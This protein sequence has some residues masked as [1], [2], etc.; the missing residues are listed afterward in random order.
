MAY[1]SPGV[2]I[3]EQSAQGP[4]VPLG[5][6]T[7]AFVGPALSGPLFTPT[8]ITNFTQ[9]RDTF[10]GYISAPPH[11]LA[12]AAYGFFQN[13]GSI[14]Y[15]VR[16]G[17]ALRAHLMLADGA[18]LDTVLI[19][20]L[21]EGPAGNTITAQVQHHQIVTANAAR[22]TATV[23]T[24]SN[25]LIVVTDPLQASTFRPGDIVTIQGQPERVKI[26][27][28]R[29]VEIFLSDLLTG[30]YSSGI[31]RIAD[32]EIGQESFRVQSGAGLEAGSSIR[33]AQGGTNEN[34]V[35]AGFIGD[36]VFLE[37]GLSNTYTMANGDAAVSIVSF[38]FGV[39][40]NRPGFPAEPFSN[41]AMD[42]RHSRYFGKIV[43]SQHVSAQLA[44]LPSASPPPV[45]RPAVI[46][47]TALAGGTSDNL[48]AINASHYQQA[49][50]EL[51][52][53]DDVNIVAAPDRTDL[54][55]QQAII[56]HCSSMADRFAILDP[57]ANATPFGPGGILDQRAGLESQ[58]GFAALYYPRIAIAGPTGGDPIRDSPSGHLAGVYAR[59]D[60][61]RGV[62]KA[63]ANTIIEGA[64]AL[65]RRL[66]DGEL[67]EL[68]IEGVNVIH[69]FPNSVRPRVWGARTTSPPAETPWRYINVRRLLLQI[70]E[71]IQESIR[72][73]VFEP[74]DLALWEKLKRI[75]TQ[76]LTQVWRDGAL[77]G[78]T[79][80]DAFYVKCD[81]E[82]NPEPIRQLGQVIVEIGVA[83]VRP[84]E[85][86]I[87]R[88]GQWEGGSSAGES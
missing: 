64:V 30:T 87:I 10:G 41:L 12:H 70:E 28:V 71:S 24:A 61:Q 81:E 65:E 36:R 44:D 33:I 48:A 79:A 62:H 84:A 9:F 22:L 88:I 73:S 45:N 17:T 54:T 39:I 15:I 59:T 31:L 35:V 69:A 37:T 8:K 6:S 7:A 50:D 78:K 11:Y 14:A 56:A 34:L 20:A 55:T 72:W 42:T 68:N 74:N 57:Q 75:I 52:R 16:V 86:V 40:I 82:L 85:F 21:A 60:A 27:R 67:G 13:G 76:Y 4:I 46:A 66:T 25:N 47:A 80:E 2:K 1:K 83:P 63:P 26:D 3:E 38:E 19:E 5:T 23:Q 77:F 49:L 18:A 58:L 29:G 51:T 32:L 43:N 53:V